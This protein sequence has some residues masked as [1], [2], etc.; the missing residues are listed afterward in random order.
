MLVFTTLLFVF[1]DLVLYNRAFRNPLFVF[2]VA[3]SL[4]A[5]LTAAI[6][7]RDSMVSRPVVTAG[8]TTWCIIC[9]RITVYEW[10]PRQFEPLVRT[11]IRRV[12]LTTMSLLSF[13]TTFSYIAEVLQSSWRA[14]RALL[15]IGALLDIFHTALIHVLYYL[16]PDSQ[17]TVPIQHSSGVRVGP[18]PFHAYAPCIYLAI[19]AYLLKAQHR[20]T[21]SRLTGGTRLS[22]G[23]GE[24]SEAAGELVDEILL[25]WG[26]RRCAACVT[27]PA[28]DDT[29]LNPGPDEDRDWT[30]EDGTEEWWSEYRSEAMM[31]EASSLPEQQ[32][33]GY[34]VQASLPE[35]CSPV[36]PLAN[37]SLAVMRARLQVIAE[38]RRSLD[39]ESRSL[40]RR[41]AKAVE[42]KKR[43]KTAAKVAGNGAKGAGSGE[44]AASDYHL[45]QELVCCSQEQERQ[46]RERLQERQWERHERERE[47]ERERPTSAHQVTMEASPVIGSGEL[48]ARQRQ[49][50]SGRAR[51]RVRAHPAHRRTSS[52]GTNSEV[53][54][55][56]YQALTTS[57]DNYPTTNSPIIPTARALQ[58]QE[59]LWK[60]LDEAG[61]VPN[62]VD[63]QHHDHLSPGSTATCEHVAWNVVH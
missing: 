61:I 62:D 25:P 27:H 4:I 37:H 1:S 44:G 59:A 10:E 41:I 26:A 14:I 11:L 60:T 16:D 28:M 54:E 55:L 23:L 24:L 19:V 47:R 29:S 21:I 2:C 34:K 40:E 48:G 42:I 9:A 32:G 36:G 20:E 7:P 33:T 56:S 51:E 63:D 22:V 3:V 45:Q 5:F 17:P 18:P 57:V 39:L 38:E 49:R 52:Y 30:D 15:I 31:S 12:V 43:K 50:G 46:L 53:A 58:R 13:A 35:G 8:I 6:F